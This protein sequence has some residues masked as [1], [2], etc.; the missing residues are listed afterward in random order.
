MVPY[1]KGSESNICNLIEIVDVNTEGNSFLF[2]ESLIEYMQEILCLFSKLITY[3]NKSRHTKFDS[4]V[5][6]VVPTVTT[7]IYIDR[8]ARCID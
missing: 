8:T 7:V 5:H 2:E 1:D 3:N 6:N 4:P